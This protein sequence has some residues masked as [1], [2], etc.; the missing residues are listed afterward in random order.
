MKIHLKKVK[1]RV[2]LSLLALTVIGCL[3]NHNRQV[4]FVKAKPG[5][6]KLELDSVSFPPEIAIF[7]M[8]AKLT[9]YSN[10]KVILTFK[11]VNNEFK[12]QK[13][14]LYLVSKMDT[15]LLGIKA[16]YIVMDE[17]SSTSFNI[18]GFYNFKNI[19]RKYLFNDFHNFPK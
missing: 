3:E 5:Q 11:S 6:V 15:L 9:N 10:K 7:P 19:K 16:S 18:E 13:E 17:Y 14:N 2:P 8:R 4:V 12:Y 1:I